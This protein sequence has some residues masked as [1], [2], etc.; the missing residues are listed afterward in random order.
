MIAEISPILPGYDDAMLA[1]NSN[2]RI[3]RRNRGRYRST[4]LIVLLGAVL[5]FAVT[6]CLLGISSF[7]STST[8][9]N[10]PLDPTVD[11]HGCRL[12]KSLTHRDLL[13]STRLQSDLNPTTSQQPDKR[14]S[15]GRNLVF[16]G[17]MTAQKYVDSRAVTIN[18]TWGQGVP[19]RIAYFV[20]ENTKS[21]FNSLPL[22]KLKVCRKC[23]NL[24]F[25]LLKNSIFFKGN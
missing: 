23:H 14:K 17:V 24:L 4:L 16:V 8:A 3:M 19:G 11:R 22:V 15:T 10:G 6:M 12:R 20:S 1:Q 9:T 25:F 7:P 21:A 2:L 5:G 13:Q 18:Q